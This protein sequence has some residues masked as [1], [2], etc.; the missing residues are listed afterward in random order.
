[1]PIKHVN[2]TDIWHEVQGSGHALILM[3]GLGLDHRYYRFGE[4]M[5]RSVA[6]TILVDPRG[7]GQSQKDHPS[8]V[9][10]TAELWADD[11]AALVRSLGYKQVDVLGSSLGG[12]M[13]QAMALRHPDL[14]RSLIV[15]GAFADLDRAVEMNFT[16]RK[17]IIAKLGMGEEI[18]EFMSLF[19]LTR[20]FM[21]TPEGDTVMQANK[22]TVRSNSPELYSAFID[23]VLRWG[24]RHPDNPPGEPLNIDT[25]RTLRV[26]TLCVAGDNDYFI[27]SSFTKRIAENIPGALYEEVKNGGHIPFIE[28]PRETADIVIRFLKSLG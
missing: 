19:T 1:M 13:A 16:L 24:K 8:K 18:A 12:A 26:P 27:P 20:E 9:T 2:G 28:K 14:V 15:I 3:P 23:S 5:L 10:Y 21:E 6:T 22:A 25:L 7:I 4:P 17:K 11:F